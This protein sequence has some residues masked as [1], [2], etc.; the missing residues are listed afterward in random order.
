[1][2][3]NP[4]R[5]S[6]RSA[7]QATDSTRNGWTANTAATT[8]LGQSRRSFAAD[9]EQQDRGRR[10]QE[11]VGQW[12]PPACRPRSGS[13][14]CARARSADA[15]WP[16]AAGKGPGDAVGRQPAPRPAVLVDVLVV[17]VVDEI[18]ADSLGED[19]KH[20]Q[21]RTAQTAGTA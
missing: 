8:A 1:M 9:E 6:L 17:V 10:V 2:K 11:D 5:T 13:R 3:N 15:N 19:E 20:G 16:R 4:L 12:C 21:R 18:E 7:T 14:A